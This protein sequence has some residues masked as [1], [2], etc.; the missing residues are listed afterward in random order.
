M[1]ATDPHIT[2]A[3]DGAGYG[4]IFLTGTQLGAIRERI[5]KSYC[6]CCLIDIPML[7]HA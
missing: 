7:A 1:V 5:G 3:G 4:S 2:P 6:Y